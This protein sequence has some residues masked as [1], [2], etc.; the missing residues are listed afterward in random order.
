MTMKIGYIFTASDASINTSPGCQARHCWRHRN[1]ALL[2]VS[3]AP[4]QLSAPP[5]MRARL[6]GTITC[7][8]DRLPCRANCL[9]ASYISLS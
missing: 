3:A 7:Q 6:P 2:D 9:A 1:P 8:I 5:S 4:V